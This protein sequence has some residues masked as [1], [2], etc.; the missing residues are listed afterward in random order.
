MIPII[1]TLL[2][3][4]ILWLGFTAYRIQKPSSGPAILPEN[5][6][7]KALLVV[8]LQPVFLNGNGY[9][10]DDVAAHR[11]A[12]LQKIIQ[13]KN[14]GTKIIALQQEWHGAGAKILMSLTAKGRGNAGSEGLGI[15]P[16]IAAEADHIIVKHIQDAFERPS[17]NALLETLAVGEVNIIGLD[18]LYCIRATALGAVNRGYHTRVDPSLLLVSDSKKWVSIAANLEAFGVRF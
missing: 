17:L 11:R 14:D 16:E 10:P 2:L 15:L 8:D 4:F 1:T 3:L 5:R 9:E 7:N 18:G 6:P 13:E 12:V